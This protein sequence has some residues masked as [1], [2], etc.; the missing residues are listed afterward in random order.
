MASS[1]EKYSLFIKVLYISYTVAVPAPTIS[2]T[3]V[4]AAADANAALAVPIKKLRAGT[5]PNIKSPPFF[6]YTTKTI[7][8][9]STNEEKHAFSKF[10]NGRS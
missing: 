3:E 2:A 7:E 8:N 10:L 6:D 4:V 1:V 5:R 9:Q